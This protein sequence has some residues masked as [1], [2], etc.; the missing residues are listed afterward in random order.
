MDDGTAL[1]ACRGEISHPL[2]GSRSIRHVAFAAS[3][4]SLRGPDVRSD[5]GRFSH[6][7]TARVV[8]G[9][10]LCITPLFPVGVAIIGYEYWKAGSRMAAAD[11][12]E[13]PS[14]GGPGTDGGAEEPAADEP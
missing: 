9:A 3:V 6:M 1:R 13:A 12:A 8:I 14:G 4:R 2:S 5:M 7:K 10:V 11:D